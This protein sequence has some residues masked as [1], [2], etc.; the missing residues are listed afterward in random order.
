M[1]DNKGIVFGAGST[2]SI[3][4]RITNNS[5]S[6]LSITNEVVFYLA[7]PDVD[8]HFY[9]EVK[10]PDTGENVPYKGTYGRFPDP[11]RLSFTDSEITIN[12]NDSSDYYNVILKKETDGQITS[13]S[14]TWL[15]DRA[16][17]PSDLCSHGTVT[18]YKTDGSGEDITHN[19]GLKIT[20]TSDESYSC[21]IN[22]YNAEPRECVKIVNGGKYTLTVT[23]SGGSNPG[24]NSG[25]SSDDYP[26]SDPTGNVSGFDTYDNNKK[27]ELMHVAI[28]PHCSDHYLYTEHYFNF[29]NIDDNEK[30]YVFVETGSN[31]TYHI[32]GPYADLGVMTYGSSNVGPYSEE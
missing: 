2:I 32:K 14:A 29:K 31:G 27:I 21:T 19:T 13:D 26:S 23:G 6:A 28:L 15:A 9:G 11:G 24:G 1:I 18:L 7:N 5:N 10:D 17:V 3:Q 22:F 16:F 8:N 30:K 12:K 25:S 20:V 4:I